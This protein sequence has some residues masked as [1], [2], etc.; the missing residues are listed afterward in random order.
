MLIVYSTSACPNCADLKSKFDE[1]GIEYESNM[2]IEEMKSLGIK[3]VPVV[4]V[5]DKLLNYE[6]ALS[7]LDLFTKPDARKLMSEAK[8]YE[9]YSRFVD[10]TQSY[11]SWN[12][13]VSRVMNMHRGYLKNKMTKELKGY[14]DEVEQAYKD[15][16]MLG[17]QRALQFG[18]KQLLEKNSRL[19]NC[20]ASYCDRPN[21]FGGL[22]FLLL[23]GCGVGFSVQKHHVAKLPPITKRLK[24]AK[25]Y[26]VPDSIEGWANCIDVLLSSYFVGGGVYPEYEGRKIYFD[27]SN[28]RPKGA[29]ISGGFRAPGPEPLRKALDTIE[30]II[31][32]ELRNGI[33]AL[34]PIIAYD[35]CMHVADSVI[36]GGVRRSACISV[37]SP[38]DEDML[39]AKTG[40]WFITNPQRARSNNSVMLLRDSITFEY[41]CSIMDSVKQFGEPG[42][43]WA[44]DLEFIYNPCCEIGMKPVTEDGRSGFQ[45]CNLVEINGNKS[46]SKEIFLEQCR[47]ASILCT[48]QASY[49]DFKFLKDAT[50][51]IVEKEA[52]IGVGITGMM[53][54]PDILFDEDTIREG[55]RTVKHWNKIVADILGINQAARTTCIKPSGN[56]AVLL[57]CSSGIHGEHAPTYLRG[58][59][60]NKDCEVAKL[61]LKYNPYMCADSVYSDNDIIVSFPI[62]PP[63]NSKFKKD[64]MGVKQLEY[65]KCIQQ[66]WIEEGTNIELCVDPRLRHN[67]SNTISVD[68]WDEVTKYIY[69]NRRYLC[70]V[71]LLAAEGDRA[72]PQAPFTEVL[73][74]DQIIQKY[75]EVALFTSALIEAGLGA[76]NKD[77]WNACATALGYGE[78]LS[79]DN[80]DDLLKRDFV[81]RFNKFAANFSSKEECADCLKD[82]CILHRYWKITKSIHFIDWKKGLTKRSFVDINTT[83]ATGCAGGKCEI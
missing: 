6:E 48:I 35:I 42:F 33:T 56:S 38:D 37:F 41:F 20:A 24:S 5:G 10:D 62:T 47:I 43:I 68:D 49:T 71:S 34:R 30:H 46:I 61:F 78:T 14:I 12:E 76:F 23:S 11:E 8:F 9:G 29:F 16:L 81:R 55:A 80:H 64:L 22:F 19:Y 15:K 74:Q 44:D 79:E 2:N 26:V 31:E 54:N 58:I 66:T 83:G 7:N 25:T 50:K 67:V 57:Q 60:F 28:I 70:G 52:L 72:Y 40:D 36:A 3:T 59:T 27:L 45:L 73:N 21:F 17:A 53:N 82:I 18:G 13:S 4:K 77:L 63:V 32:Q 69:D 51:E 75:G 1:L 39:K 65:V